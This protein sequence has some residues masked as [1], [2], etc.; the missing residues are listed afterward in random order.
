MPFIDN[1]AG[2][3]YGGK[4]IGPRGDAQSPIALVGEAPGGTEVAVGEPFLGPAGDL[5]R[6]ALE[7][8]QVP[9]G[10]VFITNAV[11]CLPHP[12]RPRV[13]AI[14]SCQTRLALDLGM[15][16]RTVIVTLGAT[17]VRAVTGLRSFRVTKKAPDTE[18]AS[19]WGPV[20]PTLHPAFVLRR[21]QGGPEFRS[22]VNDVRRAWLLA[23]TLVG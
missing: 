22:L 4:S 11:A 5:L 10:K 8:A 23:T 7:A 14:Q 17:A 16:D 6:R 20:V 1:C 15:H 21:G 9:E 13:T 18:L 3:P 12:V 19:V 2:C